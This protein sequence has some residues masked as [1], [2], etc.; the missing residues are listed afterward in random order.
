VEDVLK[1]AVHQSIE[2]NKAFVD[3]YYEKQISY[4]ESLIAAIEERKQAEIDR[5]NNTMQSED[6]KAKQIQALNAQTAAQEKQI[7]AEIR[8][9]KRQQAIADR[10]AAVLGVVE[11]TAVA[12]ASALKEKWPMN[13]VLSLIY[14][15]IG[16]AQVAAIFAQ[17]LPQYGKGTPKDDIGHPGGPAII[18]DKPEYVFEPGKP[19]YFTD[20]THVKNLA[21]HTRVIP[22][23]ELV[24]NSIGLMT[25]S[26]LSGIMINGQTDYSA[27]QDEIKKGND[28][29]ADAINNKPVP[30][31]H[32]T[33]GEWRKIV[34][35][36]NSKTEYL[37]QN[38]S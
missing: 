13:L 37:N 9:L 2:T 11:N 6:K 19:G 8:R 21:R 27:L 24:A 1:Q 36:G 17:P 26:L 35:R 25:P 4:E 12:V 38:F 34:R 29:I 31:W 30:S 3:A 28:R 22:Q 15:G 18:G 32:A 5:I 20:K 33:G 16:T 14:A 23:E 7:N 10:A